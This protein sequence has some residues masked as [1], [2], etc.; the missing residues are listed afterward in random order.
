MQKVETGGNAPAQA[1]RRTEPKI[2]EARA[3]RPGGYLLHLLRL[4]GLTLALLAAT[5]K[6]GMYPLA[7]DKMKKVKKGN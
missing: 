5:T 7:S 6:I 2:S 3:T 4:K 1:E